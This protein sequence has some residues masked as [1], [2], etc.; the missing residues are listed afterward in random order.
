M[1][2]SDGMPVPGLGRPWNHRGRPGVRNL[3]SDVPGITVGHRDV[4]GPST[5]GSLFTG[6]TAVMPGPVDGAGARPPFA[7]KYPA[8]VAVAN[9]FGK[10][11]GLVQV[12][13][14]G[15]LETPVLLTNT[16]SCGTAFSALVR[17]SLAR[18]PNIG[19][20]TC[21]VNPVVMECNDG[22]INDIRTM[23]ITEDDCLTALHTTSADF[24]EGAVGG[25][26][27]MTC[28]GLKGGIGSASRVL[29]FDR[30]NFTLG[31]LVMT[32]F[33]SLT[34]LR[35]DGEPVGK[36]LAP[37][38][39]AAK[40]RAAANAAGGGT[41]DHDQGSIVSVIAT[42]LPMDARQLRR[43]A[44]RMTVAVAR[45]G[46]YVGNGSGEIALAF[47]T[48]N[49]IDH[50]VGETGHPFLDTVERLNDN[51]MDACFAALADAG[52]EAIVS[53]LAHAVTV[54]GRTGV[55]TY[56]LADAAALAGP[57]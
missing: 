28:L 22:P 53:S 8:G 50:R 33:G 2:L 34:R 52:E 16:L 23:S 48:A 27:G 42:D 35:L 10:S 47:S 56:S 49:R 14:L 13:E 1:G 25:G 15:S 40:E 12:E 57:V 5:G 9:G 39:A 29:E 24:A 30:R 46:G 37:A 55:P 17:W 21:T 38:V 6:V 41:D 51:A 26:S 19:T 54:T 7:W 18:H 31:V 4:R 3:I 45:C 32:N 36:R 44:G 11:T 20:Q 43:L